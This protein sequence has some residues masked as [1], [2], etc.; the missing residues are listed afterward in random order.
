[1]ILCIIIIIIVPSI[2]PLA[3]GLV[4]PF[5]DERTRKK[6]QVLGGW[7]EC[8]CADKGNVWLV[9]T[10]TGN[11]PEELQKYIHPDQL[12]QAFGGNRCEPDPQCTAYVSQPARL[13]TDPDPE[14]YVSVTQLNPGCDIPEQY[15]LTNLTTTSREE[16]RRLEVGSG[17]QHELRMDVHET[18][19]VL[20]WEFLTT[21]FDIS[22]GV[23]YEDSSRQAKKEELVSRLS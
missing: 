19:S 23:Y 1:M 12:P 9:S 6:M 14:L 3:Y 10:A 22:F 15:Y 13:S 7:Y 17:A 18:E 11:W 2:F 16:M 20:V 4:K 5:M 8:V 21:S